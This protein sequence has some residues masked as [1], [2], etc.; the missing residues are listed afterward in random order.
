MVTKSIIDAPNP[1]LDLLFE[2]IVDAAPAQIWAAWTRPELLKRWFTP[3]PWMTVDCEIDLRPGGIFR[4]EMRGPQGQE[5]SNSGCYLEI[6]PDERLVWTGALGPGYRPRTTPPGAFL[7]TAV[8]ALAPVGRGTRYTAQVLHS[9]E[10]ARARRLTSSS[11][12]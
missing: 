12:S 5:I 10:H 6:V 9:D 2:R 1:A 4:T 3:A 8:I 11:L 7:M